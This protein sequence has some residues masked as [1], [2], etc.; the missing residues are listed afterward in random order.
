MINFPV[1]LVV[2]YVDSSDKQWQVLFDTY[3]PETS[4][5][6]EGVNARNRFRGQGDFFRYFFRCITTN[7][8]WI[9]T[10]HLIVQSPSQVPTWLNTDERVHIVLHQDIIPG[11]YL[12]TFNSTCIEMFLWNIVGLSEHFLY[13]NDDIFVINPLTKHDFFSLNGY[14]KCY[15][16][17]RVNKTSMYGHHCLNGYCLACG[18]SAD[19]LASKTQNIPAMPHTIRPYLKSVMTKAFKEK[20]GDIK[21][22][23]SRFRETKN[24]NVYYFDYY[25]VQKHLNN[26]QST[27][28]TSVINERTKTQRIIDILKSNISVVALQDTNPNI[29]LYKKEALHHAF[30]KKFKYKSPYE[31]SAYVDTIAESYVPE[32]PHQNAGRDDLSNEDF[33]SLD[34]WLDTYKK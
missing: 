23:I 15:E 31:N 19:T 5:E 10:I 9:R 24:I 32:K 8:P 12:P 17:A 7:L 3:N 28:S 2:P 6:I 13:M 14:P 33:G 30:N 1:D 16:Y 25:L 18:I 21:E 22:S 34:A 20:E 27:I 4:K 29:D 26:K 11:K